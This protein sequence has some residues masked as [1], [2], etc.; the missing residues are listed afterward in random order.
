MLDISNMSSKFPDEII[1]LFYFYKNGQ[2]ESFFRVLRIL[3]GFLRNLWLIGLL[4]TA[5]FTLSFFKHH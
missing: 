5:N 1:I 3:Y 4:H 2:L